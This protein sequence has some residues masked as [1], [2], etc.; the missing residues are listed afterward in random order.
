[1]LGLKRAAEEL[2]GFYGMDKDKRLSCSNWDNVELTPEQVRY[3]AM[4]AWVTLR[5]FYYSLTQHW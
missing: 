1:M 5:L 4:D 2:L 3:A